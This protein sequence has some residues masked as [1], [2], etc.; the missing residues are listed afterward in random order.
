MGLLDWDEARVDHP[1]LDLADIRLKVL[2]P[3]QIKVAKRAAHAWEAA[4]GW[5]LEPDYALRRLQ[6]LMQHT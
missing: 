6:H 5:I 1:W 2:A 3:T 4:P